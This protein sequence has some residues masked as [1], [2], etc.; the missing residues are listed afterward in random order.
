MA[1][2]FYRRVDE[3]NVSMYGFWDYWKHNILIQ[4]RLDKNARLLAC[5][6]TRAFIGSIADYE[7]Q[8]APPVRWAARLMKGSYVVSLIM[9]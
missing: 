2:G 3:F 6:Y 7:P 5:M 8:S 9:L 1:S 4:I